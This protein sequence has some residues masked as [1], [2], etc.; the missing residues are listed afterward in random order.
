MLGWARLG[1]V[2]EY[3]EF[4]TRQQLCSSQ[5]WR[6]VERRRKAGRNS[7]MKI[8]GFKQRRHNQGGAGADQ[9]DLKG[10]E[11]SARGWWVWVGGSQGDGG[12][13]GTKAQEG[14]AELGVKVI[15]A[16]AVI[17]LS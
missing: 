5:Q 16:P 9:Q 8:N 1:M 14:K 13:T 17:P 11:E 15:R 2:V 7:G 10:V 6:D 3:C 12:A 4:S